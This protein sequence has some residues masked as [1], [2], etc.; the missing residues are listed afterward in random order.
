MKEQ[1]KYAFRT[2][3]SPRLFVFAVILVMNLAFII[4]DMIGILPLP[5]IITAVSLSGTAIAVMVAF[6][7]VGDVSIIR[8]MFSNPGAVFYALTPVSRKKTLIANVLAMF[9]MDFVTMAASIFSVVILSVSLGSRYIGVGTWEMIRTNMGEPHYML[10][11][12]ALFMAI[13]FLVIAIIMFCTAM[14]KSIFYNKPVGGLLTFLLAVGIFYIV[15]VSP[16]LLAPFADVGRFMAFFTVTVGYLGMGLYALL[17]L[18]IAA[19]LF[20]LTS[21]LFERKINI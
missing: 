4:L 11:Y 14:R 5:A 16:L 17:L 21:N 3:A 15:S 13:Y 1:F 19:V 18:I 9:V 10:I 2:G 20:V 7:I 8:S 12:L 6:N